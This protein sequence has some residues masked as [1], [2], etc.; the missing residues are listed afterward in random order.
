M[1]DYTIKHQELGT[2]EGMPVGDVGNYYGRLHIRTHEGLFEWAI[3]NWDG[4]DW[5][6]CPRSLFLA[7][8]AHAK[9][10]K[11]VVAKAT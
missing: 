9:R 5:K 2:E 7:L 4:F 3:E 6:R 11:Q 8:L 1:T 10:E